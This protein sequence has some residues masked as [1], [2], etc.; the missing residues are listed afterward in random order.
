MPLGLATVLILSP[1]RSRRHLNL[2]AILNSSAY[3]C[4][5]D[6]IF[7]AI[8]VSVRSRCRSFGLNL[9]FLFRHCRRL[10][11][12]VVSVS[13][14][15]WSH[16]CAASIL[17]PSRFSER[18]CFSFSQHRHRFSFLVVSLS[19][20]FHR[21]FDFLTCS[22]SSP[23]RFRCRSR[24]R[25]GMLAVQVHRRLCCVLVSI[26][27]LL[28]FLRVSIRKRVLTVRCVSA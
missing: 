22:I 25:L 14:P 17:L 21:R 23:S 16:R 27:S 5:R 6:F 13:S 1:L 11:L 20:L 28:R 15:C 26:S 4:R 3:R 10:D 7:F 12:V 8:S 24:R 19:L 9:S 18:F 2:A